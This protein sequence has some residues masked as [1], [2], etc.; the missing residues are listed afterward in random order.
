MGLKNAVAV[1]SLSKNEKDRTGRYVWRCRV[2]YIMF[3]SFKCEVGPILRF[4]ALHLTHPKCTHTIVNTHTPTVNTHPEQWAA[5]LLRRPGSSWRSGALLR[6]SPQSWY[7]GWKRAWII[8]SPHLQSC[9]TWDSNPQPSG[10]K[11]D[12]L[13][14][15]PRL[16]QGTLKGF[17]GC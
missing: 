12:S 10:Y 4:C 9:R 1:V 7:W 17:N 2:I 14:I 8:H 3:S 15:R 16:P 5:I 6:V 13:N 11:S